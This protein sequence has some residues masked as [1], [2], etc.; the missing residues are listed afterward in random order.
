MPSGCGG[1]VPLSAVS[2]VLL[3]IAGSALAAPAVSS[4][5]SSIAQ[6]AA[7]GQPRDIQLLDFLSV[8]RLF[9]ALAGQRASAD[10]GERAAAWTD[11][12]VLVEAVSG[13]AR[14]DA[15]AVDNLSGAAPGTRGPRVI[16]TPGATT[17]DRAAYQLLALGYS[18]RET[19]D[20]VSG[21]I[22]QRALDTAHKMVMVGRGRDAA[23]DYLDSQYKRAGAPREAARLPPSPAPGRLPPNPAPVPLPPNPGP[24]PFRPN[25]APGLPPRSFDAAIDKYSTLHGVDAAIIRA[26]IVVES[27]FAPAARSRAGAIGLM[28]LMPATARALGVNPSI[29]EQNIEGG[30]RYLSE[31]LKMFGGIELALVAYNG[32]PGLARRYARGEA[33]LYGETRAYVNRVLAR[34]RAPR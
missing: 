21:R 5:E 9:D 14:L 32:G 1:S 20:V 11:L 28:Q 30:V 24:V 27:A 22:T 12:S 34:I 17:R 13:G 2:A 10:E 19:A 4:A 25:P 3:A 15:D 31:L 16:T 23:A 26:I 8:R 18:P 33:V 29:P 7:S 6:P